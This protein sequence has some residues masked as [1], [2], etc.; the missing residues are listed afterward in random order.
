MKITEFSLI[1]EAERCSTTKIEVN[2]AFFE[3]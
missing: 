2:F 3:V 1:N